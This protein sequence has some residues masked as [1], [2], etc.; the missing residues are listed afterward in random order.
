L[1]FRKVINIKGGFDAWKNTNL[2]VENDENPPW[3]LERQV[4]LITGL[5]VLIG[6]LL[7]IFVHPYFVGLAG[8]VG[9]GLTLAGVTNSCG[10]AMLLSKM[11]W[12]LQKSINN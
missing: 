6:V 9:A 3:E 10:M 8:F 12:N 11:P 1:G 4:R 5:L 2:P 7:S